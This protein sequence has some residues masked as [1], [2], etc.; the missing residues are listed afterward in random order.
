MIEHRQEFAISLMC[1]VLRVARAGFYE[2]LRESV[3]DRAKENAPLLILI[4][5]SYIASRI[6]YGVCSAICGKRAKTAACIVSSALCAK[7]RSRLTFNNCAEWN[8]GQIAATTP[9]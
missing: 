7:T 1:R 5:A 9:T 4:R 6:V 3:C 2:W 8:T